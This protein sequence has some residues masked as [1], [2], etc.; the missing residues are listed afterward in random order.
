MSELNI[1]RAIKYLS[2]ELF[3]E[4][5]KLFESDLLK[6]TI[7]AHFIDIKRIWNSSDELKKRYNQNE[8]SNWAYFDERFSFQ[9]KTSWRQYASVAALILI[10]IFSWVQFQPKTVSTSYNEL[11]TVIFSDGST[12]KLNYSTEISFEE[13]FA[14]NERIVE[15]NGEAFFTIVKDGRPFRVKTSESIISVLG[16]TFNVKK[17]MNATSVFVKSGTVEVTGSDSSKVILTR[18]MS[19]TTDVYKRALLTTLYTKEK[20]LGWTNDKLIFEN[21]FAKDIFKEIF[22]AY[23]AKV[24][25]SEKIKLQKVSAIFNS[26]I[27][28]NSLIE[29]LALSLNASVKII[30]GTFYLD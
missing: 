10:T 21:Q 18:N 5:L 7:N 16:T 23:G 2:N 4:D 26:T 20:Q 13:T 15:L 3:G 9:K 14:T 25:L 12:A 6:P 22:Y 24:T 29:S 30:D 1:E 27:S 28:I 17:R 8:L 19:A 11:R